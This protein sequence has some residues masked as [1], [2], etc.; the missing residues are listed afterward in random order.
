MFV[1]WNKDKRAYVARVGYKG[2]FTR[3]LKHVRVFATRAA[4]IA[5]CCGNE[6]VRSLAEEARH[7][8]E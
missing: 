3:S 1:I 7:G 2:P 6:T 8:N 4:A 5:D